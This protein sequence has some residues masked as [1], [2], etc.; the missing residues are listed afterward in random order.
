MAYGIDDTIQQKVDAY[1][2]NPGALQKRYAQ[3]KELV[4]LL[5]L[6]KLKSEK[7]AAARDMQMQMQQK[8]QTIAQQYEAELAGRTKQEMLQGVA[9]VMQN[10]Q[11][12]QQK[13]LQR[14][15][16]AGLPGAAA[17][18]AP[19]Q[20]MA[21]G[22]IVGFT[23]GGGTNKAEQAREIR[24]LV[25]D[26]RISAAE[27][28]KRIKAL[29]LQ[30]SD[31]MPADP[32]G[33]AT[34]DAGLV[35]KL[36]DAL[37]GASG[38]AD[39]EAAERQSRTDAIAAGMPIGSNILDAM[40]L[41]QTTGPGT[42]P[43]PPVDDMSDVGRPAGVPDD[44]VPGTTVPIANIGAGS[45]PIPGTDTV[46]G[47]DTPPVEDEITTGLDRL[48]G[49]TDPKLTAGSITAGKMTAGEIKPED[50]ARGE[51]DAGIAALQKQNQRLAMEQILSDPDATFTKFADKADERLNRTGVAAKYEAMQK[52]LADLDA[53]QMNPEKL[54]NERLMATLLGAQGS[55]FAE[56]LGSSGR[57]GMAVGRQQEMAKRQRAFDALNLQTKA[58][59]VDVSIGKEGVALGRAAYEQ[60][61]ADRRQGQLEAGKLSESEN[62]KL[63]EEANRLLKM[64]ESNL[65]AQTTAD[66]ANLRA[67]TTVDA[68][69]IRE[70]GATERTLVQERG[71]NERAE[72]NAAVAELKILSSERMRMEIQRSTDVNALS[73]RLVQV[74]DAIRKTVDG[75]R[76][77]DNQYQMLAMQIASEKNAQKKASLQAELKKRDDEL[78]IT[79]QKMANFSGL[80][81]T[82]KLIEDR[83][84]GILNLGGT[85]NTG[86]ITASN[87]AGVTQVSP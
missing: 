65:D 38:A 77:T 31:F 67:Q 39:V 61:L 74:N 84:N 22:G 10:R 8:P 80:L 6:Q 19:K 82:R 87:V 5:A 35:G 43:K 48:P 2:G 12:K 30:P 40:S 15:A 21:Q 49:L 24:E 44:Y 59:D 76:G 46:A 18:P 68:A 27:G 58:I 72:L 14:V 60:S 45:K 17:R 78:Y 34:K 4:D 79:A 71:A 29:G 33:A 42:T 47:D 57:A 56:A 73:G 11:A 83:L 85:Q 55:T 20:M 70:R 52:R 3:N 75:L 86:G 7:D 36:V 62:K 81:D 37:G 9:G 26:G 50:F 23:A 63:D 25:A 28:N 13:N 64:A 16:Q 69:N 1:R 66:A 41:S 51:M 54:R 53:E 32:T